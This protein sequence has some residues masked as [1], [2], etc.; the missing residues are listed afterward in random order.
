MMRHDAALTFVRIRCTIVMID[1]MAIL[2]TRMPVQKAYCRKT[3]LCQDSSS[4]IEVGMPG[5]G[6]AGAGGGASDMMMM[7]CLLAVSDGCLVDL[8]LDMCGVFLW[9]FR[10]DAYARMVTV[11]L[12]LYQRFGVLFKDPGAT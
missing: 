11:K 9:G 6:A 3:G 2:I 4:T 5:G 7:I 1:M 8:G 12:I 10:R